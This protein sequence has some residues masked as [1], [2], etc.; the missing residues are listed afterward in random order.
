MPSIQ[1]IKTLSILRAVICESEESDMYKDMNGTEVKLGAK[2]RIFDG[3]DY[4]KQCCPLDYV[5]K[6]FA[7]ERL[8]YDKYVVINGWFIPCSCIVIQ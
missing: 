3:D 4:R 6:E 7:V 1:T 5:G 2:V 8:V